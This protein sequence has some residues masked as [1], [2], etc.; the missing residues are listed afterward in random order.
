L[1][2]DGGFDLLA[3]ETF[4]WHLEIACEI[5]LREVTAGRRVGFVFLDVVNVDEF[6]FDSVCAAQIYAA[7]RR[8]RLAKVQ[9]VEEILQSHGVTVITMPT[10]ADVSLSCAETG[11]DSLGTL[12]GLRVEGAALGI[13]VLSS[14]I[15][16]SGDIEPD[17][18]KSRARIDR[19][20][21]SAYQAF[22]LTQTLID[23]F[24]PTAVLVYNSRLACAK[25]VC[26]AARISGVET[27]YYEIGGSYE[28]FYCSK[29]PP[30]SV[31]SLRETVRRSWAGA[32]PDREAVAAA[33]FSP[34][35]G[36]VP[37]RLSQFLDLQVAGKGLPATRRRRIAY[38]VSSIDEY[39]AIEEGVT[40]PLFASQRSAVEWL[41]S[42]V[43]ARPDT[44]LV[45][46]LHPRMTS[47]SGRERAWWDGLADVN[48]IVLPA[49]SSI[50]SYALAAS[51]DRVVCYHSTMGPEATYM[52]ILIGDAGYRGLDC[53]Y[54]PQTPDELAQLL[55]A[56]ELPPKPRENCLPFGYY[57]M[58]QGE[59][60]RYF[61]PTSY[62]AGTFFG[63]S[64]LPESKYL[65]DRMKVKALTVF[66]AVIRTLTRSSR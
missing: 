39:A 63:R 37:L 44:E 35:R 5:C 38:Y 33:F 19:M 47:V 24:R 53:V 25:A 65:G 43:L 22:R 64:V 60:F 36:G 57:R 52:G 4:S 55:D 56:H 8:Y 14:L 16:Q 23:R 42:W 31:E 62:G 30:Q 32:G 29:R 49:D 11:M 6:A 20:L 45:V 7:Q 17:F 1:I 34:G 2:D 61:Q 10:L 48:V 21:T 13:G 66:D 27:L 26:E 51:A 18:R 12:R 54:E 9:I 41:V 40:H 58:R 59:E 3:V 50:D 46:R 15:R 28:R